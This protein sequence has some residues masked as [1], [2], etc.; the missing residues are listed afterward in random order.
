MTNHNC[1]EDKESLFSCW[2]H[3]KHYRYLEYSLSFCCISSATWEVHHL[4]RGWV[5]T[6]HNCTEDK[7]SLFSSWTHQEHYLAYSLSFCCMSSA[8]WEV[9]HLARG[10]VM[11][12]H[13]C[14][15]D[16]ESLFS[17]WTHQEHYLEN[18]PKLLLYVFSNLGSTS[19]TQ[20]MSD[21]SSQLHR[22]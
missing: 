22:G 12:H 13:N 6:H 16:K 10:W 1:T 18:S 19:L 20:G 15:E 8:T 21:D 4:A 17:S 11:T 5:M 7:E 3:H 14:T 9:H 2:T